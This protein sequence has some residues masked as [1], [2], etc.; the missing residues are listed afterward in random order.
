M[1]HTVTDCVD[2][3]DNKF[4]E[5]ALSGDADLILTGDDHLLRLRPWRGIPILTPR[6]FLEL[7]G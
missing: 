6:E 5:L 4:L 3:K 7:P 1:V 2:P